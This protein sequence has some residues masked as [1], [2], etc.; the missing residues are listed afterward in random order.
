MKIIRNGLALLPMVMLMANVSAPHN[1]NNKK[2]FSHSAELNTEKKTVIDAY[3]AWDFSAAG[4]SKDVFYSAIKGYNYL[5]EKNLIKNTDV[6]TIV[7][8]SQPSSQKRLYV[9]D[10]NTGRILFNTLAAH[11]KNSGLQYATDFSNEESSNKTS[12]GFFVTMNTYI[13]NNGYSLRLQGCERGINDRAMERAIVLHGAEYVNENFVHSN[14]YLGRS[15]GC[16]AVPAQVSKSI[17]DVIKNG[18]CLFLYHPT[19]KYMANSKILN[20]QA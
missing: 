10:M 12:L 7:D 17:I 11:G 6:L 3:A 2:I 20:S 8:Y 9:L 13:G 14:G 18:S 19:K 15:H 16:P 5:L 4:L 1:S